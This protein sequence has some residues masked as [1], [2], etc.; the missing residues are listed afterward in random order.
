MIHRRALA[1][2]V[3]AIAGAVPTPSWAQTDALVHACVREGNGKVRIVA[4]GTAC[5]PKER[6]LTWPAQAPDVSGFAT[7]AESDARYLAADG[8]ARS[9]QSATSCETAQTATSCATA[10]SATT[11]QS[12]VSCDHA[13]SAGSAITCDTAT[14]C[15]TADSA[16]SALDAQRVG[17]TTVQPF[18]WRASLGDAPATILSLG[19]LALDAACVWYSAVPEVLPAIPT[20]ELTPSSAVDDAVLDVQVDLETPVSD[21]DLDLGEPGPVVRLA[22]PSQG[23]IGYATPDGGAVL[24]I[25]TGSTWMFGTTDCI[26]RGV[27]LYVPPAS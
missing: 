9:A 23:R 7:R 25:W 21:D 10:D 24:V 20:T 8:T 4:P 18:A 14:T 15:D 17:G 19:G 26:V 2:T 11:C 16:T 27:A 3:L 6:S 1:L 5:K 13:S 12:A 22:L